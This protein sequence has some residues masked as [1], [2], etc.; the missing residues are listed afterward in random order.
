MFR[1]DCLMNIES[2]I[3]FSGVSWSVNNIEDIGYLA[4]AYYDDGEYNICNFSDLVKFVDTNKFS[5]Q[6][7][8]RDVVVVVP[9]TESAAMLQSEIVFDEYVPQ[10][11]IRTIGDGLAYK[12]YEILDNNDLFLLQDEYW[13][14][15]HDKLAFYI[16][17]KTYLE[18][19]ALVSQTINHLSVLGDMNLSAKNKAYSGA[20]IIDFILFNK[21]QCLWMPNNRVGVIRRI[22]YGASEY[23]IGLTVFKYSARFLKGVFLC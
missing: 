16:P 20:N 1:L 3:Y 17:A 6:V 13:C 22:R 15:I 12:Y 18:Q 21:Q 19:K 10:A 23:G 8:N 7:R 11:E 4:G 5:F 2:H 9:W 14:N